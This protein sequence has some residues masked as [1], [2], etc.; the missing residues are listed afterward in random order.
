MA[1]N[2]STFKRAEGCQWKF[3]WTENFMKSCSFPSTNPGDLPPRTM[4]ARSSDRFFRS[5]KRNIEERGQLEVAEP[6]AAARNPACPSER[7]FPAKASESCQSRI[8]EAQWLRNR[9]RFGSRVCDCLPSF[10]PVPRAITQGAH[11][12][13]QRELHPSDRSIRLSRA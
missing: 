6:A 9:P 7:Q 1:R 12:A 5:S 8:R 4:G 2:E 11:R 13:R 3:L 10:S